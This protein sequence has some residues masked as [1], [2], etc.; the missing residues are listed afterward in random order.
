M[1]LQPCALAFGDD[2]DDGCLYCPPALAESIAAHGMNSAHGTN[3]A[4]NPDPGGLPCE[5]DVSQCGL[6]DDFNYDGRAVKIK[7]APSDVLV[8]IAPCMADISLANNSPVLLDNSDHS[9]LPGGS[10]PLNTLYCVY[11]I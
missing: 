1:A 4:D 3:D 11:L 5:I 6:V 9:Y 10:P 8:G 2:N 7:D